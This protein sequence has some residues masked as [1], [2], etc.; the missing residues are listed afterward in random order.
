VVSFATVSTV[1]TDRIVPALASFLPADIVV[2]QVEVVDSGFNARF[3][4]LRKRYQYRI[5]IAEHANPF[6]R[7]YAWQMHKPLQLAAMQEATQLLVGTHDFA[8]FR[9][10]GSAAVNTIKTMFVAQW[11]ELH[12]HE[13][14]FTI[15]GNGFLY[16]M[17]RS[18]VGTL[19]RVG[20]GK[21]TVARFQE[22]LVS[23]QRALAGMAAPPQGLYLDE[24]IYPQ[25][26][27]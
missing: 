5:L 7:H 18:I 16:H 25:L 9:S 3:S 20:M 14:I 21:L 11:Q 13:L 10:Q 15:E 1:P 6:E 24:V 12:P 26:K 19:V 2:R 22:I 17:V 27:K 8:A 4:A 23:K